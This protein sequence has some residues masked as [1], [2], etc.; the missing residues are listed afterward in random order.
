MSEAPRTNPL[1]FVDFKKQK[2]RPDITEMNAVNPNEHRYEYY[3]V[4][5]SVSTGFT[6]PPTFDMAKIVGRPALSESNYI[7]PPHYS[8]NPCLSRKNQVKVAKGT[9]SFDKMR[10]WA[11]ITRNPVHPAYLEIESSASLD[12]SV[13]K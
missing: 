3:Y 2:S 4:E 10:S 13:K 6:K 5:P 11:D 1:G 8:S 9:I 12:N 7:T